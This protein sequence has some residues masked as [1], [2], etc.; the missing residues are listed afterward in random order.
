MQLLQIR[1]RT[2]HVWLTLWRLIDLGVLLRP[3]VDQVHVQTQTHRL[4]IAHVWWLG[5]AWMWAFK[6]LHHLLL[7]LHFELL[8]VLHGQSMIM[9]SVESMLWLAAKHCRHWCQLASPLILYLSQ[10]GVL[11]CELELL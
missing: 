3:T 11:W 7:S 8:I 9:T 6:W 2:Y 10:H 4:G 5:R 1:H